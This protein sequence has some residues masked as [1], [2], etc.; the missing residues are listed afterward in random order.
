MAMD[1]AALSE[2]LKPQDDHVRGAPALRS[3]PP[4]SEPFERRNQRPGQRLQ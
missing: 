2:L 1:L 4:L 3:R